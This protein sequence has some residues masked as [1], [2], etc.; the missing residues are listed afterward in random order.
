M[1]YEPGKLYYHKIEISIHILSNNVNTKVITMISTSMIMLSAIVY[2]FSPFIIILLISREITNFNNNKLINY[3]GTIIGSIFGLVVNIM[4]L[5]LFLLFAFL[6]A[7]ES[8]NNNFDN[9]IDLSNVK[10][11]Y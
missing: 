3:V 8:L 2:I 6:F 10:Q 7:I 4:V 9:K 11:Q 1:F 5:Q